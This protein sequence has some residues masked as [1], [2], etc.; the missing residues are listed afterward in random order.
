MFNY[1]ILTKLFHMVWPK[2][3]YAY[4]S[5]LVRTKNWGAE[6]L[7]DADLEGQLDLIIAWAMAAMNETTG[8]KHDATENEGPKIDTGGIVADAVDG[9]LIADDAVDSEHYAAGSVDTE[10]IAADQITSALIADDQIDSEHYVDGSVDWAHLAAGVAGMATGTYTGD[11]NATQAVAGVGFQ[12]TV[13][14]I[15]PEV[16]AG[17]IGIK[18]DQDTTGAMVFKSDTSYENDHVVSLGADGF[19]VGDGTGS[20]NRMNV[21]ARV[22]NYIAFRVTT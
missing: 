4:S 19:T 1:C 3:L 18:T 12:P 9:T 13:L 2:V 15:Y 17:H 21:N 8:H 11:G 22:Y 6:I 5:D 10:H 7:T 16:S 20:A 14:I